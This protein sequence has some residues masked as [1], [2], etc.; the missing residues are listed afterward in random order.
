MPAEQA[1]LG[2]RVL[3]FLGGVEHHLDNA[4]DMPVGGRQC[5]DIESESAGEGGA[6]LIDVEDFALD[7]ARFQDVLGQGAEDGL[8][9]EPEAEPSIRPMSRP[10]R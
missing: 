2:Q 5:P 9:A 7:L 10:C 1:F 3:I 8:L 6:Y 4:V